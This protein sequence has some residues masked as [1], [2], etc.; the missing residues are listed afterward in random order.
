MHIHGFHPKIIG[1]DQ[2]AWDWSS[3]DAA[4]N[5]FAT[6]LGL[7][8]NTFSV[9]SGESY[10]LLIDFGAQSLNNSYAPNSAYLP[11]TKAAFGLTGL[12]PTA[13][14]GGTQSKVDAAGAPLS[15]TLAIDNVNVLPM[16]DPFT[17]GA[18]YIGGPQ[19]DGVVG[20]TQPVAGTGQFFPWHNH[21]DYKSTNN[22]VYPGGQ[23]VMLQTL[24]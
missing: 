1:A 7:E 19:V 8:R 20:P 17:P 11:E 16:P 9:G 13:F 22:G 4:G 18:F 5:L 3:K 2:R 10:E 6:G 24:P 14:T 23:F 12:M 15:N 21:D